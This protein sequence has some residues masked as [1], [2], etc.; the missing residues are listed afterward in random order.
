MELCKQRWKKWKLFKQIAEQVPENFVWYFQTFFFNSSVGL[1][2]IPKKMIYKMC[3]KS[4][5]TDAVVPLAFNAFIPVS[6]N[7]WMLLWNSPWYGVKLFPYIYLNGIK[8]YPDDEFGQ[9]LHN[10]NPELNHQIQ[11]RSLFKIML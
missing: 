2:K 7:W 1:R 10:F 9:F 8:A 4:I 3:S 11:N 6:F 5:K